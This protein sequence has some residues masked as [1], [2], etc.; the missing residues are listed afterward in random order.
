MGKFAEISW[1]A[2]YSE[3]KRMEELLVCGICY[4]YMETSVMTPCSH[5]YCSLCI[6][7][8]LHYK[9]Q[10]P[11]CF[12]K[13]FEKD[14]HTNRILDEII[15]YFQK[16]REKLV[17]CIVGAKLLT[18][19]DQDETN[20]IIKS[21]K[22]PPVRPARTNQ[23]LK[24]PTKSDTI[25]ES[26]CHQESVTNTTVDNE[27]PQTSNF[28]DTSNM[29]SPSTSGIPKIAKL[30]T[31][32]SRKIPEKQLITIKQ[33]ACPVCSVEISETHINKH[34]DA[35][36]KRETMIH[37]PRRINNKRRPLPKLVTKLMKD[38]EL[39]KKM[40]EYNLPINGDRKTLE[41]RFHKYVTLYNSEC[42][43]EEPRNP[44]ELVKQLDDEENLEK[45]NQLKNI[46]IGKLKV[47]RNTEQNIIEI[48]QKNYLE[49]NKQ[50]FQ[51]LID[52]MKKRDTNINKQSTSK[53][54][55]D[56]NDNI[57]IKNDKSIKTSSPVKNLNQ[58]NNND[59]SSFDNSMS[60]FESG[61]Q[62]T[63]D[64][65]SCPLQ[66]YTS[67]HP[68]NF[69]S[70][71][72]DENAMSPQKLKPVN[73]QD[74]TKTASKVNVEENLSIFDQ[75][76]DIDSSDNEDEVINCSPPSKKI[77]E[78]KTKLT[79]KENNKQDV[80]K[81][82]T[83]V[84]NIKEI[85]AKK[86]AKSIVED[87]IVD[88]SDDAA[89]DD[90]DNL[91]IPN[92]SNNLKEINNISQENNDKPI[93][94]IAVSRPIRKRNFPSRFSSF[95]TI[96]SAKLAQPTRL[97]SIESLNN[98]IDENAI[99]VVNENDDNSLKRRRRRKCVTPNEENKNPPR[100]PIRKRDLSTVLQDAQK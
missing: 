70:V 52:T 20:A 25:I 14:L 43:K 69:L 42:D 93:E 33:V 13:T 12:E 68:V 90:V 34:L 38:S 77:Q 26:N 86:L 72:I 41:N 49:A 71:E 73:V 48:A 99:S 64:D 10:C 55:N 16:I 75:S 62:D 18:N 1:P 19:N 65:S 8:Y 31:P 37:Q 36:L 24:T 59:D 45:K 17:D 97:E 66:R 39:K 81:E 85:Q 50:S 91:K 53:I 95:E 83:K 67:T 88:S 74:T 96:D 47:T 89:D 44:Q 79:E 87:F 78:K 61:F 30:F 58:S 100:R 5:N 63:S 11:A 46:N 15:I 7:K 6:R 84:S 27:K 80:N 57:N 22:T 94:S 98:E 9:T 35:C 51:A 32:K 21:P 92:D 76:T 4:D 3:L 29:S 40:K 60:I 82:T 23:V 56:N 2:D 54:L 28:I